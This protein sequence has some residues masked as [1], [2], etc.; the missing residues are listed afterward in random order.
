M[1]M[2]TQ[3]VA[4]KSFPSVFIFNAA[5]FRL[6]PKY[7]WVSCL[8]RLALRERNPSFADM[9]PTAKMWV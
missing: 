9:Q 5:L 4:P 2:R 6:S 7:E 1:G 3:V 8:V